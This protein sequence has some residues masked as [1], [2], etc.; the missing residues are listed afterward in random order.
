MN[1]RLGFASLFFVLV[2]VSLSPSAHA[3][4]VAIAGVSGTVTDASGGAASSGRNLEEPNA[5]WRSF[6]LRS[7]LP[8]SEK[9]AF[10]CPNKTTVTLWNRHS[11]H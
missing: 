11:Q 1:R 5:G 6:P 3:Q 7:I 8:P 9:E 4:A 10:S 2:L